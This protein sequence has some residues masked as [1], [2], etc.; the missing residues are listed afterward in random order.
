MVNNS[1]NM[2]M[3][4]IEL[5]LKNVLWISCKQNIEG[6]AESFILTTFTATVSVTHARTLVTSTKICFDDS[7]NRPCCNTT[8]STKRKMHATA[9]RLHSFCIMKNNYK[10][11]KFT[12][13]LVIQDKL[14]VIS[15][16]R[17][18]NQVSKLTETCILLSFDKH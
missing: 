17:I 2:L 14:V 18:C 12:T 4:L 15:Q 13:N 3:H 8:T 10:I 9:E 11:H 16:K 6:Y 1:P 5:K 7:P